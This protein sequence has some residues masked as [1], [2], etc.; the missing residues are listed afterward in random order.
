MKDYSYKELKRE[1]LETL[2][3]QLA[4]HGFAFNPKDRRFVKVQPAIR[5]AV[6]LNFVKHP[7]DFDVIV[8]VMVRFDALEELVFEG[9]I[10]PEPSYSLGAQLGRLSGRGELRWSV[11][12]HED[13]EPVCNSL[14]KTVVNFGLPYLEKYSNM[15]AA[16]EV[17]GR[18]DR[19][20]WMH[21]PLH[22]ARAERALG[23]AFLVQNKEA[24]KRLS[25]EKTKFLTE[26]KDQMLGKFL[27]FRDK[28]ESRLQ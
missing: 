26:Q 2:G 25:A 23:L 21:S 15:E 11:H 8:G 14:Y 27:D 24:F 5:W 16:L 1:L 13:I 4:A 7:A 9:E 3:R 12:T 28:L 20:A 22:Y 6:G 19:A 10:N 17:L 18:D